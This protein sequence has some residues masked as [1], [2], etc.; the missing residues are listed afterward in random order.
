VVFFEVN[1]SQLRSHNTSPRALERFFTQRGY[2]LFCPLEGNN[3]VLA[4]VRSTSLLTALIAPKAWFFFGE[5]AP[6]DLL[7]VPKERPL[8]F[9][10]AGFM[11]AIGYAVRTNIVSKQKRIISFFRS[12]L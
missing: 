4:Y 3:N 12:I 2:Q 1:L 10:P 11:S 9:S 7:A 6:F 5:S 8:P